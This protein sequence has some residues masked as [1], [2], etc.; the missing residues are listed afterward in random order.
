MTMDDLVLDDD[1]SLAGL[2]FESGSRK[3]L[4]SSDKSKPGSARERSPSP[5]ALADD[6]DDLNLD[7]PSGYPLG[8]W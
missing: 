5:D 4:K 3:S 6:F 8:S 1:M 7:E 2:D